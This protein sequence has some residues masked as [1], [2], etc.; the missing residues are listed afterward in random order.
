M[1]QHLVE[2]AIV[3]YEKDHG[4]ILHDGFYYQNMIYK[5]SWDFN[6]SKEIMKKR[7][8]QLGY[9]YAD[10][11]FLTVDDC[12]YQPFSFASGTLKEN[13]TFVINRA[14]RALQFRMHRLVNRA[15]SALC[16]LL[17]DFVLADCPWNFRHTLLLINFFLLFQ[18][19][20]KI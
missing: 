14:N 7:F 12:L 5:L 2:K 4:N 19:Q 20:K 17:L 6:V 9:D 16:D 13:E 18:R 3:D 1:D 10:G 15:H 11:T 8:R